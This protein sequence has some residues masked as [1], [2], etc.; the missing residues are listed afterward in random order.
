METSAVVQLANIENDCL[1]APEETKSLERM[2]E[3]PSKRVTSD[4]LR[5]FPGVYVRASKAWTHL[6]V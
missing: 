4:V 3:F 5:C 1:L 6:E 2:R